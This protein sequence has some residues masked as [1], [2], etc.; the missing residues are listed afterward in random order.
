L[1]NL[2]TAIEWMPH[3]P[4]ANHYRPFPDMYLH[5]CEAPFSGAMRRGFIQITG[6]IFNVFS[7]INMHGEEKYS[8]YVW[9]V[10]S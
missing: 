9:V 3:S 2:T 8:K 1:G 6:Y 7:G 4:S 10:P 5:Y